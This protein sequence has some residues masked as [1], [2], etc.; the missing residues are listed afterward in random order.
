MF[1]HL[2]PPREMNSETATQIACPLPRNQMY[3]KYNM[4]HI[5]TLD[6]KYHVFR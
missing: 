3:L 1:L 2:S 5:M 6:R 4:Y